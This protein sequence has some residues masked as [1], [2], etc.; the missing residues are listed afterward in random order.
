MRHIK[1]KEYLN[2]SL[3]LVRLLAI[4]ARTTVCVR[5]C[6]RACVCVCV[7]VCVC[8]CV[9]KFKL[10]W[11]FYI[12]R[13]QNGIGNTSYRSILLLEEG[14]GGGGEGRFCRVPNSD[15]SMSL[16]L[17]QMVRVTYLVTSGRM[18]LG[19]AAEHS[20]VHPTLTCPT[21]ILCLLTIAA[22][23]PC[24]TQELGAM[25]TEPMNSEKRQLWGYWTWKPQH[26]FRPNL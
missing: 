23:D 20:T 14:G 21:D 16:S 7:C 12:S 1:I 25:Q 17:P 22:T 2:L 9:R 24:G 6:V 26:D 19:R 15:S 3:S 10:L 8:A 11:F 13:G 18:S 5:A 4:C